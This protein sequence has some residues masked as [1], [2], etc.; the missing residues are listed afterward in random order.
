MNF[1]NELPISINW[2]DEVYN[3]ILVI[4]DCLKKIVYY[5][6][7]NILIDSLGLG[8]GMFDKVIKHHDLPDSIVSNQTQF[9]LSN[10]GLSYVIS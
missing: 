1:F 3:S 7:V 2:K 10:F 4:V 5:K 8:E 9:S 6:S